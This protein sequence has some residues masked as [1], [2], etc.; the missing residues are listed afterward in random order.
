METKIYTLVMKGK[1]EGP[2]SLEELKAL[3]V[4]PDAFIRKP[5]MDDYKEAHEFEELRSLFGF[6]Q[7]FTAPQYFA[8]F[9]LRLLAAA[10][11]WFLVLFV[12]AVAEFTYILAFDK[13]DAVQLILLSNLVALPL[14][15]F[16]YQIIAETKTQFTVGKRM[17]NIKVTNLDGLKP[18]FHQIFIRNLGKIG[19]TLTLFIGYLYSFLNKKQQCLHD[20][21]AGTLVIKERLI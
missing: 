18:S 10:I 12:V 4:K 16:V 5:G 6:K 9:D 2:F 20:V 8:G 13:E 14:L 21:W 17:L 3:D 11:D 7:Q 15:K 19:S 1:P